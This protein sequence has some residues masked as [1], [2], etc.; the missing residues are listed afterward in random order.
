VHLEAALAKRRHGVAA[1]EA[2]RAG[3]QD[4]PGHD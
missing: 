2:A 1:D 4:A 3:D